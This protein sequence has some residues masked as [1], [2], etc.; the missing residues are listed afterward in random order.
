MSET[1]VQKW[2]WERA[3][4]SNPRHMDAFE[5]LKAIEHQVTQGY[6]FERKVMGICS[7]HGVNFHGK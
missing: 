7:K 1:P 4:R 6:L 2:F 5:E 3:D